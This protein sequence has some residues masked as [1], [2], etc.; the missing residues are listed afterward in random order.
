MNSEPRVYVIDDDADMRRSLRWLIESIGLPVETFP[1]AEA[2][3]TQDPLTR[4]GC[5]ILD[6][7]MPGMGG[8]LLL[9]HLK[10]LGSTLPV[11]MFTG[12]G[13]V[14]MAVQTL[15]YGAFDFLEKP[16]SHQVILDRVQ[17]A[18]ALDCRLRQK[19]AEKTDMEQRLQQLT[20]RER[21]ILNR[22]IEGHCTL[23]L[24]H[25]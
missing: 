3:L 25:I 9:E 1:S 15:K 22:L 17:A 8:I 11:I 10:T 12:H 23:S 4:Q 2:F 5:L 21:E 20:P 14:P 18:L 19:R 6:V 16:A 7:R 13:E 24:I